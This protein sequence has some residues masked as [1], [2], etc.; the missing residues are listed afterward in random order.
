MWWFLTQRVPQTKQ[1]SQGKII[2]ELKDDTLKKQKQKHRS[3]QSVVLVCDDKGIP[4]ECYL[5][6]IFEEANIFNLSIQGK[7]DF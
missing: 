6:D 7:G 3:Y 4:L 5:A 2:A 1:L